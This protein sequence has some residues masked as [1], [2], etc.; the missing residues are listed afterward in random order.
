[1][2]EPQLPLARQQSLQERPKLLVKEKEAPLFPSQLVVSSSPLD[3]A[4]QQNGEALSI[5]INP[6]PPAVIKLVANKKRGGLSAPRRPVAPV[7]KPVEKPVEKSGETAVI[8]NAMPPPPLA[9]GRNKEKAPPKPRKK[10]DTTT[11]QPVPEPP[12][13]PS[14]P[15][16]S[17]Q[18]I[19]PK[20][21]SPPSAASKR[22]TADPKAPPKKRLK[23]TA[24]PKSAPVHGIEDDVGDMSAMNSEDIDEIE[25]VV[26]APNREL[27]DDKIEDV[28]DDKEFDYFADD[29]F[30]DE[31]VEKVPGFGSAKDL[32]RTAIADGKEIGKNCTP[33]KVLAKGKE[34]GKEKAK[35]GLKERLAARKGYDT[36]GP[37]SIEASDL[38]EWKP[39]RMR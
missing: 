23:I 27:E 3:P 2:R 38:F 32:F 19:P 4:S 18:R 8:E 21:K 24:P 25:E 1:M 26:E 17:K 30:D 31:V 39:P 29:P 11:E 12:A 9:K 10:K 5:N 14:E 33:G 35:N 16:V 28:V 37:W 36:S 15:S 13:E 6:D 34:K 22:A 7:Q 20:F